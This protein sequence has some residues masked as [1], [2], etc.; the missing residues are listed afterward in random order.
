IFDTSAF[1]IKN[2]EV[3]N[4]QLIRNII[5]AYKYD[6]N[7][8]L[9]IDETRIDLIR[10]FCQILKAVKITSLKDRINFVTW[11]ELIESCGAN[12]KKYIEEKYF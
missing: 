6:Y 10:S 11:Q 4:Y 9:L 12:L 5:T 1:L 7:F 8:T 2:E 3:T